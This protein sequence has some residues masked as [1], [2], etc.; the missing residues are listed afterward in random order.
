MSFLPFPCGARDALLLSLPVVRS[1]PADRAKSNPDPPSA[2][3]NVS[4]GTDQ[5]PSIC[6]SDVPRNI[7][8]ITCR[9]QHGLILDRSA[10]LRKQGV[11]LEA[12]SMRTHNC[13]PARRP[14]K[15][16]YP[17]THNWSCSATTHGY[18]F[19]WGNKEN[20]DV[21]GRSEVSFHSFGRSTVR[22]PERPPRDP[23]VAGFLHLPSPL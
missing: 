8:P 23:H 11:H 17:A 18:Q 5:D 1:A 13:A 19:P 14:A 12:E 7:A 20:R 3:R 4:Q 21:P 22:P 6:M 2:R 10:S 16:E 15:R 9:N